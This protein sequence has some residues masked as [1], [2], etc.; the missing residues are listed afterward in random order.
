MDR[1]VGDLLDVHDRKEVPV[2]LVGAVIDG[3]VVTAT[4]EGERGIADRAR[5]ELVALLDICARGG[6]RP[7]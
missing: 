6:A 3:S 7:G 5:R 1:Q 4:A 2:T